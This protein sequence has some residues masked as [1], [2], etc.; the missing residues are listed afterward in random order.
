MFFTFYILSLTFF[1][2]FVNKILINNN[3]LVSETGERHQK[4]AS[5]FK[6]ALTGGIFIY[7]N[8]LY[9]FERDLISFFIFSLILLILGIL[10]DLK[11]IKSAKK[12]FI[13]QILLI[14]LFVIINKIQINDTRIYF[15]DNLIQ[16]PYINYIFVTF[17]ILIVL[18]GSNFFDGLNT[19]NVGY[20]LI[21][22]LIIYYLNF[23]NEIFIKNFPISNFSFLLLVF[24]VL[25]FLNRIYLG[26][27]GSYL[28]G[29]IFSILL[30]TMYDLNPHISPFFIILLLWYPSYETL[31]SIIR[32]NV[33]KKSPLVSD[34]KHLHQ[35]IF[36]YIKKK[37]TK[38]TYSAN[39][40]SANLINSYN[41]L[42]FL[43][44][45]NFITNTE[46]LIMLIILNLIIYTITYLKL[47]MFRFKK[48]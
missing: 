34:S 47:F 23:S 18:N 15:L 32:K 20:Y 42:F 19:L 24:Y 48:I 39:L 41:F 45:L 40:L 30:I 43:I 11:L 29:F 28:L 31:F 33:F 16:T 10:S 4:F 2:L 38:K 6:I 46:V 25:N 35:L 17:C 3:I 36:Y 22:T 44:S 9:F 1:V 7:L 21:I 8:F 26:D 5:N 14:L 27:S 37:I 12:R 13:S